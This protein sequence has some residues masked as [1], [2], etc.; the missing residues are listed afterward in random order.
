MV[1]IRVQVQQPRIAVHLN[2]PPS[3]CV[4]VTGTVSAGQTYEGAYTITPSVRE[5]VLPTA[6]RL[7]R[8]DLTVRAI[9]FIDVTNPSG[10]STIYIGEE[11]E[12][13]GSF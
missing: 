12:I 6:R 2:G 5:T 1:K 3:V 4:Q 13:N 9:P 11:I 10:G 7:M 8:E